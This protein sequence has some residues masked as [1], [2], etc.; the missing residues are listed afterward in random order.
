MPATATNGAPPQ[1][2]QPLSILQVKFVMSV[3]FICT[4]FYLACQVLEMLGESSIQHPSFIF[5]YIIYPISWYP[6][7]LLLNWRIKSP[8]LILMHESN[9]NKFC[10]RSVNGISPGT[11]SK[12]EKREDR[13]TLHVAG[14]W[15]ILCPFLLSCGM[16]LE[17][18]SVTLKEHSHDVKTETF[19]LLNNCLCVGLFI[20]DLLFRKCVMKI[21]NGIY[22]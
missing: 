6:Y 17:S 18:C 7:F 12:H 2:P 16:T 5:H 4:F 22:T 21:C 1:I 11:I 3:S 19:V 14:R 8:S 9:I 15:I 20:D 13:K 10:C